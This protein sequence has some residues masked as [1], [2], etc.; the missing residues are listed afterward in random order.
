[1]CTTYIVVDYPTI[2]QK[3]DAMI[4]NDTK[5]WWYKTMLQK[6]IFALTSRSWLQL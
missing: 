5:Q 6:K 3:Y 1:M 2:I 4:Q